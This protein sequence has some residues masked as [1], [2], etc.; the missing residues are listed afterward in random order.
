MEVIM[1]TFSKE[2]L[3]KFTVVY[4]GL[5]NKIASAAKKPETFHKLKD[6]MTIFFDKNS[7]AL[8]TNIV[9][10]QILI[11]Q[12]T[13]NNFLDILNITEQE[14]KDLM[15]SS[16][17]FKQFGELQLLDQMSFA[18]P[19]VILSSEYKKNH[20][21]EN[22]KL[23]YLMAFFKPYAS[24]ES[25]HFRYG[26]NEDQMRY[27]VENLSERFDLKKLGTVL[28][29]LNK[30]S[31]SSY[32]NY[33][34]PVKK[35]DKFTDRELHVIYTS[36]IASNVNSFLAN[37]YN[38]Y[39]NNAGNYLS[40]EAESFEATDKDGETDEVTTDIKSDAAVK[41]SLLNKIVMKIAANPVDTKLA[42]I[43]AQKYFNS[44]SDLY[45]QI[46]KNTISEV[47]AKMFNE[48]PNF[49][50]SMLGAFLY[51]INPDT[52]IKYTAAD[53]R[54]PVFIRASMDIFK[55][56]KNT[57]DPNIKNVT[58]IVQKMLK[59]YSTE[60]LNF[61]TTQKRNLRNALYFYWVLVA[62]MA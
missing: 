58:R 19:L 39:K 33:I 30:R 34:G 37:V 48:L 18:L 46:L 8:Q 3:E 9:G 31:L 14:V 45:V 49:F 17:Y 56:S 16:P 57:D 55:R 23:I 60:Y 35:S 50:S 54:S 7:D 29:V 28:D 5:I 15:K 53:M 47:T 26:V 22:A 27:T 11:N 2:E 4:D 62:K 36:G 61:G 24:R 41:A 12:E 6:L 52:G 1:A 20:E 43:A 13:E 25:Q 10:K 51:N 42:A 21:D 32:E 44:T 40:Y 59:S 38:A